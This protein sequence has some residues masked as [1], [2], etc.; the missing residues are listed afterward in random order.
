VQF[1]VIYHLGAAS[2]AAPLV[3]AALVRRPVRGARAWVLAWCGVLVLGNGLQLLLSH[4]GVNNHWVGYVVIAAS[5]LVL[6][7]L[8]YWHTGET[9]RLTLRVAI[10]GLLAVWAVLTLAFEDTSGF[11]RA[12]EPMAYL[13]CLVAAV[14][15]LLAR[16]LSSGGVLL[17]RDWF[18]VSAGLALYFGTWSAVGP[19]SALLAGKDPDLLMRAYEIQ[20]VLTIAAFCAIARGMTCPAAT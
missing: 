4:Y 3:A 16:S 6:W 1:P 12:A 7:A 19:L 9:A 2:E 5:A 20:M 11:S 14:Y 18:W 8:S 17:H 15:T 10:I 13:V